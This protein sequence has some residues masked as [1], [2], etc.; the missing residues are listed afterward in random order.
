MGVGWVSH[1]RRMGVALETL[2]HANGTP[3]RLQEMR[4]LG[5][6][7]CHVCD[8][9]PHKAGGRAGGRAGLL[10]PDE[11][12]ARLRGTHGANLGRPSNYLA[13][14][15]RHLCDTYATPMRHPCDTHPTPIRHLFLTT[16]LMS[17]RRG[18]S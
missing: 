12:T 13:P 9:M 4:V 14:P 2:G 16:K 15:T 6:P 7:G 11:F 1:G 8:A 10:P 17:S 5:S 18:C 3:P